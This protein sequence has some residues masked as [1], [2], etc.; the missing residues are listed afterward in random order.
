MDE[1]WFG[2]KLMAM[3]WKYILDYD[4]IAWI[5]TSEQVVK[6]RDSQSRNSTF[7][8]FEVV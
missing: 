2:P 4:S 1:F 7:K 3:V 8:S 5:K 6:A